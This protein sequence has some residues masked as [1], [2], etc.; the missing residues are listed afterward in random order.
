MGLDLTNW[1]QSLRE[2]GRTS[3]PG[4]ERTGE[5]Q[6]GAGVRWV[7]QGEEAARMG[8]RPDGGH[9]RDKGMEE[10]RDEPAKSGC[11]SSQRKHALLSAGFWPSG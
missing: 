5:V 4:G 8:L 2:N 7:V 10:S 1:F 6:A 11:C 3:P 9:Q